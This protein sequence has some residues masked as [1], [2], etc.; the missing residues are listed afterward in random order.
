MVE[1]TC[2][3]PEIVG[4]DVFEGGLTVQ[5]MALVV[6]DE[7]VAVPTLFVAATTTRTV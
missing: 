2:A 7:A 3:V 4:G 6:D 1:P 5:V